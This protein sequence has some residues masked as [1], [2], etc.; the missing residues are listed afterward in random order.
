MIGLLVALLVG[1]LFA[2]GT[3]LLLRRDP[4]KLILGLSL[5]SY[6]VNLLLFSTSGMAR[7]IPPI[8]ADKE[9]FTGDIS[10]FVDP[11]PQALI[12]T[13]IVISFGVTAFVVVLVNRR[14]SLA[15]SEAEGDV[16]GEER[17][18]AGTLGD[19]FAS[20][21]H[22]LSDLESETDD[23]EWLEYSLVEEYRR[24]TGQGKTDEGEP[25]APER[26]A[27]QRE[28]VDGR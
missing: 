5:L 15:D 11:L 22:Y 7:G 21:G 27:Q 8:V 1:L 26:E 12:L 13:A 4:I 10:R 9:S 20:D 14:N 24:R 19:P 28:E 17:L 2:T 25:P 6:A 3:Y 23:Y 18:A 16:E